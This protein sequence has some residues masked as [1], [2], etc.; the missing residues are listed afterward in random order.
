MGVFRLAKY[1][2]LPPLVLLL[3]YSPRF[4]LSTAAS[5]LSTFLL[6]YPLYFI[7]N[8]SALLLLFASPLV[9]LLLRIIKNRLF[10]LLK[11]I[12]YL[13][14]KAP[15]LIRFCISGLLL[16]LLH[17]ISSPS[18]ES[19]E[20]I[21]IDSNITRHEARSRRQTKPKKKERRNETIPH[22]K[23]GRQKRQNQ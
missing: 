14:F 11:F 17:F 3:F 21:G 9:I 2:L 6:Q 4:Y 23:H 19:L 7:F 5:V 8:I 16:T 15:P 18:S 13:F 1:I 10:T 12:F 22:K 20:D